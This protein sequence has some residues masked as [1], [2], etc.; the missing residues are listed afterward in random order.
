MTKDT[1]HVLMVEDDDVDA[2]VV[3]KAF[4]KARIANPV[5]RA[6]DGLEAL[7]ML[8][9]GQIKRPYLILLDLNMPRMGGLEFLA[10]IRADPDMHDSIVFVFTTSRDEQDRWQAYQH[11]ISG[12][13]VKDNAGSDFLDA[14]NMLDHYWRV[15]EFP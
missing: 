2:R 3:E 6:T 10:E 5:T 13:L 8:K 15:V 1:V 11:N 4:K 14:I 9:N 7:D 12:Y